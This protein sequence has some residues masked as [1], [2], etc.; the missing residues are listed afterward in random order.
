[1]ASGRA[2]GAAPRPRTRARVALRWVSPETVGRAKW[3][4]TLARAARKRL[5]AGTPRASGGSFGADVRLALRGFLP[6]SRVLYGLREDNVR[7]YLSDRER[8]LT[9]TLNWPAA[10]LLDDKLAFSF[11]LDRFA[12]PS[13]AV[14]AVIRAGV[15][16][17]LDESLPE[18]GADWLRRELARR[19]RL[20]IK[21]TRSGGGGR[22]V[23]IVEDAGDGYRTNGADASWGEIA[24]T[25]RRLDD[26]LVTE[27]VEQAA[28]AR[29]IYPRTTNTI[30]VLTLAGRGSEPLIAAAVHRFGRDASG[31][32]DNWSR[33]GLSARV[34][35]ETGVLG[36]GVSYPST[37]GLV[38]HAQHPDTGS[39]IAGTSVPGWP[40]VRSE[41]LALA[42]RASF[43]PYVGWDVVVTDSGFQVLEGNKYSDVNLLQ[44]HEPLLRD[45]RVRSFYEQHGITARSTA[46][47]GAAVRRPA[48]S[49]TGGS[50]PPGGA[51]A[52]R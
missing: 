49:A 20:V 1:M 17:P 25:V 23:R 12:V 29:A 4:L 35:V 9:W 28:Y 22:N 43:L 7:D 13:P 38:W 45:A 30:R 51:G 14:V 18:E 41:I 34:D 37:S 48:A 33:G 44:V 31:P 15:V 46:L 27:F 26:D 42:R 50:R 11:M 6:V 3:R 39:P 5:L 52:R 16:H 8:E 10:S 32:V 19:G 21:P 2:P 40:T 47:P 24:G 36:A